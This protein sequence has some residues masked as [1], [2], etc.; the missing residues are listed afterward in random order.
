MKSPALSPQQSKKQMI[1]PPCERV[2]E[3][4]GDVEVSPVVVGPTVTMLTGELVRIIALGDGVEGTSVGEA[5]LG[6]EEGI[7]VLG[8]K[9]GDTEGMDSVGTDE[10][11]LVGFNVG[12]R[13]GVSVGLEVLGLPVGVNVSSGVVGAR[14]DG[15]F[16][17]VLLG[18]RV[19]PAVV[20]E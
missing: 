16:V 3:V 2:G 9:E 1:I 11:P 14:D 18:P 19:G 13:V 15:A 10:G 8:M 20:G 17:G 4:D 7:D 12:S 6:L 5:E